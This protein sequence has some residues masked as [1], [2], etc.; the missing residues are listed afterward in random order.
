MIVPRFMYVD[1]VK[2]YAKGRFGLNGFD[3]PDSTKFVL[4]ALNKKGKNEMNF[5]IDEVKYP[6]IEN[7][8]YDGSSNAV[9]VADSPFV[10]KEYARL[11]MAGQMSVLLNEIEV[12]A[13]RSKR[14]EDVYNDIMVEKSIDYKFFEERR[15]TSYD[16]ALRQFHGVSVDWDSNVLYRRAGVTFVIDGVV[17]E[18]LMGSGSNVPSRTA[19]AKSYKKGTEIMTQGE[20]AIG[21]GAGIR[22]KLSDIE[23]AIPF[24][25]VRKIDFVL[26]H[27][28]G[29][30]GL[31]AAS[32]GAIVI[33]TKDG[34]EDVANNESSQLKTITPLG[35]QRPCEFY[36]PRYDAAIDGLPVG[37]D[38]RSTV[39]WNPSVKIG[40]KGVSELSF[41]AND[42][43]N[44]GYTITVEGVTNS[45][46]VVREV[47]VV[48]KD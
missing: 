35:Y 43:T 33:T 7:H 36:N 19:P 48:G 10:S 21:S 12:S 47:M 40:A 4:Q 41:Y 42:A 5:E 27:K 2:T 29:I 39:Y 6:K 30:Y 25:V 34:S 17:F 37:S 45:G 31:R 32:G 23:A 8:G 26:P 16:E 46:E 3:F 20:P 11:N 1:V 9:V 18:N 15:I 13:Y 44:T 22:T 24:N 38:L 14:A 28:A